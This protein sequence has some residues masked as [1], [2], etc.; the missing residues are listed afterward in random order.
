MREGTTI[1]TPSRQGISPVIVVS[2]PS[3]AG[4][5]SLCREVLRNLPWLRASVSHTTR[6]RR[7]GEKEGQ[8]YFF[9]DRATFEGMIERGEFLEWAEVHGHLYGS[10]IKYLEG[11]HDEKSLLFEVDCKG[12]RQIRREL[13][14]AALI[15]V[16]TPS[17]P[18][19]VQRIQGRGEISPEELS[20]RVRTATF[21]I[22]QAGDFDYLVINDRF[23]EAVKELQS[24]IIAESC[25]SRHR[26]PSWRKCWVEEIERHQ[27]D[28]SLHS[29]IPSSKAKTER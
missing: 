5:S 19:L 8:H 27:E 10:S 1:D 13:K 3:G 14:E 22:Q 25:K 12:A 17:L 2:G 28:P 15:F 6:P 29:P 21:E 4:K 26:V 24:I 7:P 20:V 18:D 23:D 11:L 9:V 16:M